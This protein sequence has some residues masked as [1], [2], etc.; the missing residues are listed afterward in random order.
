MSPAVGSPM[1]IG[2]GHL[3]AVVV[4]ESLVAADGSTPRSLLR[5]LSGSS[6]VPDRGPA[7]AGR[8]KRWDHM[9]VPS[10]TESSEPAILDSRTEWEYTLPQA[11]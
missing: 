8:P 3:G 9:R 4:Y 5:R 11:A 7:G 1:S 10:G 2:T 6:S